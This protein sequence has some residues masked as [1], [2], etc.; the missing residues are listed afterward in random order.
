[1]TGRPGIGKTTAVQTISQLLSQ[2]GLH[3]AGFVTLEIRESGERRGFRLVDFA[4]HERIIA[5]VS[6]PTVHSVGKYGVDVAAID[7]SC[8]AIEPGDGRLPLPSSPP[9]ENSSA[10]CCPH[11]LDMPSN[12]PLRSCSP[13]AC[14]PPC[15]S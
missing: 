11:W 10:L 3:V 2:E 15:S 14:A 4:G 9:H 7:D 5:H 12:E 8:S 1:L 6:L 13:P